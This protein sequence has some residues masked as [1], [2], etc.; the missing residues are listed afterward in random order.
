MT[1]QSKTRLGIQSVEVAGRILIALIKAGRPAALKDVARLAGMPP[2]KAHRYLVSLVRIQLV[3]QEA[4]TGNYGIGPMA[5]TLGLTGLRGVEV[6]RTAL[7]VMPPLRDEID[8][9]VMLIIWG[10]HGPVVHAFE[11]S[12]RPV[13]MNVRVGSTVPM[14]RTAAGRLFA[15]YLPA[16][17]TRD[18]VEAERRA[19]TAAG[20]E[21]PSES[22][23]ARQ[24]DEVRRT[25][26]ASVAGDLLPGVNA[27]A[28]PVFDHKGRIAAIIGALGRAEDMD[29]GFDGAAAAAVKRT[30]AEISRRI[31]YLG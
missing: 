28:A 13:F 1:G 11:E 6:V 14:L 9:T 26:L 21:P 10:S 29:V 30:A 8:E 23:W 3:S 22:A 15:A 5:I 2:G 25:G 20:L 16:K 31:G 19:L 27:I 4:M 7:E 12:S 24:L 17:Q 18:I